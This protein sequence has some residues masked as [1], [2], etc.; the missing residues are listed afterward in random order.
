MIKFKIQPNG[1]TCGTTV[2]S[3][4][5]KHCLDISKH[6]NELFEKY[7]GDPTFGTTTFS[8]VKMLNV[9]HIPFK[10]LTSIE[11]IIS[12][13]DKYYILTLISLKEMGNIPHWIIVSYINEDKIVNIYDP[14]MGERFISISTLKE[15][16]DMKPW[17]GYD[18]KFIKETAGPYQILAIKK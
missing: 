4:I 12:H 16:I 5:L 18:L 6:P 10:H 14:A 11:D 3:M 13:S 7:I 2:F 17:C 9:F 15:Y 1:Y 8:M